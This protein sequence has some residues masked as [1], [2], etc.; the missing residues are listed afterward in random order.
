[1]SFHTY[2]TLRRR[3]KNERKFNRERRL[4]ILGSRRK[5]VYW[6]VKHST[7]VWLICVWFLLWK[8]PMNNFK[9]T[10]RA[11]ATSPIFR[12]IFVFLSFSLHCAW[13]NAGCL[14]ST[15]KIEY[16]VESFSRDDG[17]IWFVGRTWGKTDFSNLSRKEPSYRI[18]N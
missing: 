7:K 12:I 18:L 10:C 15:K 9:R 3:S 5:F 11:F 16:N 17:M 4:T 6:N 2:T 13:A 1:M 14:E 8:F